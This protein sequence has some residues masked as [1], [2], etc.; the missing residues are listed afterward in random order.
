MT[1]NNFILTISCPDRP[2]IVADVAECLRDN[3]CNI[4]ESKQFDDAL[5]GYF[6]M[7]VVFTPLDGGSAD[8]FLKCFA[9]LAKSANMQFQCHDQAD[10]IKM[11]IM[12]SKTDHCLHDILYR[13]RSGRLPINITAVVSNH[14]SCKSMAE[15]HH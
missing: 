14:E 5:S 8:T 1:G 12:V 3:H 13:V 11:L 15:E 6:F 9:P 7:R 4:L 10:K 2:G